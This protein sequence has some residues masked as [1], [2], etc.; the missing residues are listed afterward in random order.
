MCLLNCSGIWY[1]ILSKPF[2]TIMRDY[3]AVWESGTGF[4]LNPCWSRNICPLSG[5]NQSEE[6]KAI[7]NEAAR[8]AFLLESW[9]GAG[10]K[11]VT[12]PFLPPFPSFPTPVWLWYLR[13]PCGEVTS[14][15]FHASNLVDHDRRSMVLTFTIA[16]SICETLSVLLVLGSPFQ[17]QGKSLIYY[18]MEFVKGKAKIHSMLP[19][20]KAI[21][22]K[23]WPII[24]AIS[25][26][27]DHPQ[28]LDTVI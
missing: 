1:V 22:M 26:L 20:G 12:T 8:W 13:P 27:I 9:G 7:T 19:I 11:A 17:N 28:P 6:T 15:S 10:T 23:I 4:A 25:I 21:V 3:Q 5:T 14:L 2:F 18:L 24:T 16:C